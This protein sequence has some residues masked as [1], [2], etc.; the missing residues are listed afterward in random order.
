MKRNPESEQRIKGVWDSASK[1]QK[2]SVLKRSLYMLNVDANIYASM[3]YTSLPDY[4]KKK[5]RAIVQIKPNPKSVYDKYMSDYTRATTAYY[6]AV[7]E[8]DLFRK[9]NG[10]ALGAGDKSTVNEYK[11]L[12]RK[13]KKAENKMFKLRDKVRSYKKNPPRGYS[14][15]SPKR[16]RRIEIYDTILAIEAIKGDGSLWPKEKFRHKFDAKSKAAVYGLKDGSLLIK[17]QVGKPLWKNFKYQAGV[18][19]KVKRNPRKRRYRRNCKCN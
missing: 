1:A 4:V 3:K 10:L 14:K 18:D 7:R 6:K 16:G 15:S 9:R 2:V 13:V 17:S 19:Y 8:V 11:E 12:R 5:L